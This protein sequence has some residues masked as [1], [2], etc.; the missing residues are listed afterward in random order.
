[1]CELNSSMVPGV[2]PA[3]SPQLLCLQLGPAVHRPDQVTYFR[4]T[5]TLVVFCRMTLL[6]VLT[7]TVVNPLLLSTFASW[8]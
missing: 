4:M 6:P 7:M 8:I 2:M 3:K 1:M 5:F